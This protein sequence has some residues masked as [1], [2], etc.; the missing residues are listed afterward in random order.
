MQEGQIRMQD[1]AM[2]RY[3]LGTCYAST[4]SKNN[5]VHLPT[6]NLNLKGDSLN[7][8]ILPVLERMLENPLQEQSH[9]SNRFYRE[10]IPLFVYRWI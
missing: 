9:L 5:E 2:T 10:R 6:R 1:E 8:V 7:Q 4:R 3:L